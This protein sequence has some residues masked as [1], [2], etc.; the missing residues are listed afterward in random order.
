MTRVATRA[1]CSM[2]RPPIEQMDQQMDVHGDDAARLIETLGGEPAHVLGSS[3]GA[4]V[5]FNLAAHYPHRVHTLVAHEPP[6][7]ELLPDASQQEAFLEGVH[8]LY[9]TEGAGPA[10][11]KF[12]A[13][14]GFESSRRPDPAPPPSSDLLAAYGRMTNNLAFFFGHGIRPISRYVPEVANESPR[15]VVGIG[16]TSTGQLAYR[17]AIALAGRL[18]TTPVTFPGGHTGYIDQAAAFAEKLHRVLRG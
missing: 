6:C 14:G 11:T 3:G 10:M 16:E 4:Q 15:I 13:G 2:G 5:G 12:I 7:V 1:A 17:I 9:R 18:G 8:N